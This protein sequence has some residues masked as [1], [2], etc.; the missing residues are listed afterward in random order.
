M[1]EEF[2]SP[3]PTQKTTTTITDQYGNKITG[4]TREDIA[5]DTIAN[6]GPNMVNTF[7]GEFKK[8]NQ[9]ENPVA[10]RIGELIGTAI[11][12]LFRLYFRL[13]KK[14]WVGG[15][16]LTLIIIA[17]IYFSN[18]SAFSKNSSSIESAPAGLPSVGTVTPTL[19][20]PTPT[21]TVLKPGVAW[22][23]NS[24]SIQIN[25]PTFSPGCKGVLGFELNLLNNTSSDYKLNFSTG[26]EVSKFL[27]TD[28]TGK[29]YEDLWV[30]PGKFD[31]ACYD[32]RLNAWW[33]VSTLKPGSTDFAVRITGEIPAKA[34]QI[35]V[36]MEQKGVIDPVQWVI[37]VKR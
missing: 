28:D 6:L 16:L 27:V 34:T 15:L 33:V 4:Q 35:F 13:W 36:K 30:K 1:R 19:L 37:P 11:V 3:L 24:L 7:E 18:P 23:G 9:K 14:S 20:M 32:N 21:V 22:R 25:D 29:R 10:F 8:A 2:M 12:Q 17:F 5:S 31:T 26:N